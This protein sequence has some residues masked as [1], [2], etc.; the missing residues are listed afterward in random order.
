[1][2]TNLESIKKL[3]AERKIDDAIKMAEDGLK[4]NPNNQELL[5]MLAD[6][7]AEKGDFQRAIETAD[8]LIRIDQK[9]KLYWLKRSIFRFKQNDKKGALEDIM[10]AREIDPHDINAIKGMIDV[11]AALGDYG[12]ALAAIDE[13]KNQNFTDSGILERK[14]NLLKLIRMREEAD[15]YNFLLDA[16]RNSIKEDNLLVAKSL[17]DDVKERRDAEYYETACVLYKK[18]AMPHIVIEL[19]DEAEKRKMTNGKIKK[20]LAFAYMDVHKFDKALETFDELIREEKEDAALLAD[21]AFAKMNNGDF[22][23]ALKD[24]NTAIKI[25][26]HRDIYFIRKGDIVA[27]ID[28][29]ASAIEH[30]N[31]AIR[32]NPLNLEAYERKESAEAIVYKGAK[33]S[34]D[35]LFR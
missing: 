30:Y 26:P 19:A 15:S 32:L 16:V 18:M 33:K 4:E 6:M 29:V 8:M 34:D 23:S 13:I 9:N 22:R 21:R 27:R 7:F 24:I 5:A 2:S 11:N 20:T 1:M 12:A 25:N 3:M 17:L 28:G 31:E 35:A 14:K 10:K